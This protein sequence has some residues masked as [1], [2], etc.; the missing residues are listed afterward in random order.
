MKN[1]PLRA[2]L[3]LACNALNFLIVTCCI[4]TFFVAT[5]DGLMTVTGATCFRYFTIDSNIL[6]A[7][8]SAVLC[9]CFFRGVTPVWARVLKYVGSVAVTVTFLTVVFFLGP[10]MGYDIMFTGSSFFLHLVCP[11]L[12]L[13]SLYLTEADE[14]LPAI[15][16]PA[17]VLPVIVYG[18]V[19]L[20]MVIVVPPDVGW[21]DFYGFNM[22]GL[23]Y[24]SL[25]AMYLLTTGLSFGMAALHRKIAA[26]G[27]E[28]A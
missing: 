17:G 22:G 20:V 15:A 5:G 21:P 10:T 11:L 2:W 4:I 23:W 24:V 18:L 9:A 28:R 6:A 12:C 7:V 26:G 25:A 8:A 3:S 14:P 1:A 13:A 16:W 19:Y 27:K